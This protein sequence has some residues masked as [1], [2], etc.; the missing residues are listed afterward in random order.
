M[1]LNILG[2]L[3]VVSTLVGHLVQDLRVLFGEELDETHIIRVDSLLIQ[4][5]LKVE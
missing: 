3:K 5:I 2:C 4:Q 1:V